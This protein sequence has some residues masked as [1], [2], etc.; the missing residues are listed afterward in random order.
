MNYITL[1]TISG[2]IHSEWKA[3]TY[4][5]VLTFVEIHET[6]LVDLQRYVLVD[7]L[8]GALLKLQNTS[9][10]SGFKRKTCEIE[11]LGGDNSK[12]KERAQML[13]QLLTVTC[14]VT[15]TWV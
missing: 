8:K 6:T 15:V 3:P 5:F 13:R 14:Y 7:A 4:Y 11:E 10:C 1:D 12:E 2:K 9:M